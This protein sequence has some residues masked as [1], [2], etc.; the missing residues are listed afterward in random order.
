MRDDAE[1]RT[2]RF[3]PGVRAGEEWRS[4]GKMMMNVTDKVHANLR[5]DVQS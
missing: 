5:G 1:T 2:P 3:S 4:G